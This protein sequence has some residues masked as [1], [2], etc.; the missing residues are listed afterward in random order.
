M[1]DLP[2]PYYA[3]REEMNSHRKHWDSWEA[4]LIS[5]PDVDLEFKD[6]IGKVV[7]AN[8]RKDAMIGKTGFRTFIQKILFE[9]PP[10]GEAP[11]KIKTIVNS[12]EAKAAF[13]NACNTTEC[14]CLGTSASVPGGTLWHVMTEG[15]LKESFHLT[16]GIA[17][18]AGSSLWSRFRDACVVKDPMTVS[19]FLATGLLLHP[20]GRQIFAAYEDAQGPAT[21]NPDNWSAAD[22]CAALGLST[23]WDAYKHP[24]NIWMVKYEVGAL[25]TFVPTLADANFRSLFLPSTRRTG[26]RCGF[27][28]PLAH[29]ANHPR[30]MPEV[31]HK[32]AAA[33]PAG[34]STGFALAV[35]L[36]G[37]PRFL[38][39]T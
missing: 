6:V 20:Q 22:A 7:S 33:C 12:T 10:Q 9:P 11:S 1:G 32:N 17:D 3:I 34:L 35:T 14:Q 19:N 29:L 24:S 37:P 16:N 8:L 23:H 27:T 4:L 26:V 13:V 39:E 5:N 2:K 25:S 15:Q 31:V 21:G 36:S 18:Y 30:G 28:R 38:G